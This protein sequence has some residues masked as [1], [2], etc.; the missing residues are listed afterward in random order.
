MHTHVL[1]L[2]RAELENVG[3]KS[4]SMVCL[5]IFH[6]YSQTVIGVP[7]TKVLK[8]VTKYLIV[9]REYSRTFNGERGIKK[10]R[11]LGERE[12]ST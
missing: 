4:V 3:W 5:I 11:G 9:I 12:R 7:G 1:L 10:V 8:L 6:A 2:V